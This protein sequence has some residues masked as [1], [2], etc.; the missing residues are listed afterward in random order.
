MAIL[1]IA[2]VCRNS[3]LKI[4]ETINTVLP[5]LSK[6]KNIEYII[7]DG[8]SSDHTME[9]IKKLT[10]GN[11]YV[12]LYSQKDRGVYDAMN[13]VI[14]KSTGK[15]LLFLN[16]D[17]IL[18][19]NVFEEFMEKIKEIK[20][21]YFIAPVVYFQ[22]SKLIIKRYW[23][24]RN[25]KLKNL[26]VNFAKTNLP[27][28]PGFIVKTS[29]CKKYPFKVAYN[30][31]ADYLHIKSITS[32]KIFKKIYLNKPLVGMSPGG[33][34]NSFLGILKA[35]T[36]I[37]GIN[38]ILKN[39]QFIFKRYLCNVFQYSLPFLLRGKIFIRRKLSL[40]SKVK[41]IFEDVTIGKI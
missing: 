40:N 16:S 4:S 26:I 32:N 23:I 6:Y 18:F 20:P 17:D 21:D 9:I 14:S 37:R 31:S 35:F 38:K 29:I 15:Y 25:Y 8:E 2:T 41:Y 1:T 33:M 24:L 28:H 13:F 30:I 36:Q 39:D 27:P 7:K 12:K 5:L 3:Q 34:S 11:K 22:R 19:H 10:L